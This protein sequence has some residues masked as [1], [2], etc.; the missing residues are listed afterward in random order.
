MS[1]K[2]IVEPR[3]HSGLW[4]Q[5]LPSH[6]LTRFTVCA[7]VCACARACACVSVCACVCA[8]RLTPAGLCFRRHAA[9]TTC[10]AG[11]L[12]ISP[13][14]QAVGAGAHGSVDDRR[15]CAGA[16]VY[17]LRGPHHV[18]RDVHAQAAACYAA[19]RRRGRVQAH[20]GLPVRDVA[21]AVPL[22]SDDDCCRGAF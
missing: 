6:S 12:S 11:N 2:L 5:P 15:A 9:V 17:P 13:G 4:F 18:A 19:A 1:A 20:A 22:P 16:C 14:G 21:C 8:W 3:Q 7:C 10:I